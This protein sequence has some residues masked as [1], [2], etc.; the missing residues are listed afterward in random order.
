MIY[1]Q[2]KKDNIQAMKD[3]N[4]VARSLYSVVMNKIKLEEIRKREKQEELVDADVVQIL[5]KTTKELEEEK[6]NFAKVGN[7]E[8]VEVIEKQI[9]IVES[10]LPQMMSEEEIKNVILS[11]DDKSVPNVMK[12]FKAN[13]NGKCEMRKVQEVLKGING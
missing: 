4:V 13:Y 1:E 11:L 9:K 8:Q 7:S 2:I 12:Y 5:Q 3:K 10:Y 6:T